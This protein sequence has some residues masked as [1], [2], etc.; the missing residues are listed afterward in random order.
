MWGVV[1]VGG[2]WVCVCGGVSPAR[3]PLLTMAP[4][5]SQH[6]DLAAQLAHP[7]RLAAFPHAT[8]RFA[9]LCWRAHLQ[10]S[11]M[12]LERVSPVTHSIGNCV[13][14]VVVIVASV[15]FF[16]NPMSTQ[17]AMG[18]TGCCSPTN[19]CMHHWGPVHACMHAWITGWQQLLGR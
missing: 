15:F 18:E 7:H 10:V 13:K 19:P 17:N 2:E 9:A 14:R 5:T 16:Q 3:P 4:H 11:Y 12:I 1:G 6:L 8:L